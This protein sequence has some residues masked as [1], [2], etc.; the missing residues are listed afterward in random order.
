MQKSLLSAAGLLAIALLVGCNKAKSPDAVANGV[1]AA[2][3]KSAVEVADAQKKAS[4]DTAQASAKVD[5]KTTDLNNTQAQGA[6]DVT[7]KNADGRH[8]VS[9]EKC[10]ALNGDPQKKCKDQ[11]DADY[12]AAKANARVTQVSTTQ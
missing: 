2:E 6:Y 11:A 3:H 12:D 9:L 8:R 4:Q 7:M 10:T 1:A 5:D